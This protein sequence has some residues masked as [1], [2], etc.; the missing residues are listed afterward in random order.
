[1]GIKVIMIG[2]IY[3]PSSLHYQEGS[4]YVFINSSGKVSTKQQ[5]PKPEELKDYVRNLPIRVIYLSQSEI[6]KIEYELTKYV[7]GCRFEK[8]GSEKIIKEWKQ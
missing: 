5:C 4:D 2:Q 3:K 1:M 8:C 7:S 6:D